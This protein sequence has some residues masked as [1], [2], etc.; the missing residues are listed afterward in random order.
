MIMQD[1]ATLLLQKTWNVLGNKDY[2]GVKIS[3]F[4]HFINHSKGNIMPF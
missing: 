3:N 2:V 4:P 1:N